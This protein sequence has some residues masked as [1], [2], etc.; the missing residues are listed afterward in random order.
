MT[1]ML[2]ENNNVP[3]FAPDF[4]RPNGL[5]GGPASWGDPAT[6]AYEKQSCFLWWPD[7]TPDQAMKINGNSSTSSAEMYFYYY[8]HPASS[9]PAG[10]NVSFCDGHVRFMSESID[11]FVF[12][13]LMTPLGRQC[14]TP[15]TVG[16][17]DGEGRASAHCG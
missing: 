16:G 8:L 14:N 5:S 13:Q 4:I 10:A 6:A 12:C 11:Y 1:L 9:H 15:G 7:K 3:Q 2:S 17:L